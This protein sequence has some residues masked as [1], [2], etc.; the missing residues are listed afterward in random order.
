[1]DENLLKSVEANKFIAT[2]DKDGMFQIFL[3]RPPMNS[4]NADMVEEINQSARLSVVSHRFKSSCVPN[5][6]QEFLWWNC[7]RRFC[8]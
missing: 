8:R 6:G 2:K 1:M 5:N 7:R 4:F 3:N